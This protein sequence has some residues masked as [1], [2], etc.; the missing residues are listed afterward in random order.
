MTTTRINRTLIEDIREIRL[1]CPEYDYKPIKMGNIQ[2]TSFPDG[3]RIQLKQPQSYPLYLI[4][5]K[6]AKTIIS[7]FLP[8]IRNSQGSLPIS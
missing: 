8:P 4:P 6:I 5:Y 1:S 2:S 3:K 7:T